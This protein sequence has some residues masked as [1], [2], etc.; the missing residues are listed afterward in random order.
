MSNTDTIAELTEQTQVVDHPVIIDS[1]V[2]ESDIH[3]LLVRGYCD[4]RVFVSIGWST[5]EVFE[6][7]ELREMAA[8]SEVV[9]DF[10]KSK[11]DFLFKKIKALR[12]KHV[13]EI[14]RQ[15][16]IEEALASDGPEV[17]S[18]ADVEEA[19]TARISTDNPV[20][21]NVF[22]R[23]T[24][25]NS[26]SEIVGYESGIP[27]G[28]LALL[29]GEEGVGKTRWY[30]SQALHFC[31][32]KGLKV[33]VFQFEMSLAEFAELVFN[34]C[35]ASG[36]IVDHELKARLRD[37]FL[38]SNRRG[39]EAQCRLITETRAD[40][41]IWDSY[42]LIPGLS[43]QDAVED[44]VFYVKRALGQHA[45]GTMVTH[46]N[47]KGKITGNG[48]IRYITDAWFVMKLWPTEEGEVVGAGD[49]RFVLESGKNRAGARNQK[50]VFFHSAGVIESQLV[51]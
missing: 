43:T 4:E 24:R 13:R 23:S 49:G 38:V 51:G 28:K 33:L 17:L 8:A 26:N 15:R 29:G 36:M 11:R 3:R 37:N 50:A 25:Y 44:F 16:K 46:L 2:L 27:R 40:W 12:K 18:I 10:N 47:E 21:D 19:Y 32:N 41:V 7:D 39:T 20:V 22:G 6:V 45:A 42:K 1:E 35:R 48:F 9:P 14:E 34:I 31:L 5:P 30:V